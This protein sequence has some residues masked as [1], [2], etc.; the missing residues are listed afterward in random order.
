MVMTFHTASAGKVSK[1]T[2]VLLFMK[3]NIIPMIV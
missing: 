2:N 1:N 3:F